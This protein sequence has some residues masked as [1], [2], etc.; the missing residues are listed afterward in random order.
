M[1]RQ[2]QGLRASRYTREQPAERL[3]LF[4]AEYRY[5]AIFVPQ[6]YVM[7]VDKLASLPGGVFAFNDFRRV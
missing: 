5:E 3:G 4:F 1:A 2:F 7:P 6:L